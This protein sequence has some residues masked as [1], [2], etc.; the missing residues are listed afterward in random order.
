[1]LADTIQG[2]SRRFGAALPRTTYHSA[3]HK[4][5]GPLSISLNGPDW[6]RLVR[7]YCVTGWR[8]GGAV[9]SSDR[10]LWMSRIRA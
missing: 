4:A 2:T 3:T 5:T 1:M 6:L 8:A 7:R 9:V 10:W